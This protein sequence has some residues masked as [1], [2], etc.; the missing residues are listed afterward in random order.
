M[1]AVPKADPRAPHEINVARLVEK[2]VNVRA[3]IRDDR[4]SELFVFE[5]DHP[6]TFVNK[7]CDATAVIAIVMVGLIVHDDNVQ[8]SVINDTV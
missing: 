4:D 2:F 6:V 8:R 3:F 5:R 7:L 1:R